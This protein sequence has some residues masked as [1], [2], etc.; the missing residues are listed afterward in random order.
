MKE[1]PLTQG[2]FALVDDAE[3]AALNAHKWH[4]VKMGTASRPLFYAVRNITI[5]ANKGRLELMHRRIMRAT[6]GLVVDHINSDTL[7]NRRINLRLCS[8]GENMKNMRSGPNKHGFRGIAKS[9]IGTFA[10]STRVNHKS[11]YLGCF[12]TAELAARAYDAAALNE[13]GE[14]A[15][16]NF[17][18]AE[19]QA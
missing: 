5:A 18:M 11:K 2:L 10:A 13:F 1:I 3:F 16:L 9:S 4:A 14:F 7:D 12:P 8:Q 15:K 6:H 19:S 17:P